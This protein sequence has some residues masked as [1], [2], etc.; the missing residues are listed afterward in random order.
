M[1][2][3]SH[4]SVSPLLRQNDVL[5]LAKFDEEG[6][7]TCRTIDLAKEAFIGRGAPRQERTL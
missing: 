1:R 2:D 4:S 5:M 6:G 3:E 7:R